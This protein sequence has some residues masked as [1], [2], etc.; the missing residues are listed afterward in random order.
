VITIGGAE[1]DAWLAAL[2]Y[3]F[4]RIMALFSSAPLLS[5][6]SV[7]RPARIG[8][9]LMFTVL[10]APTLPAVGEA[11]PMSM[12]G[13]ILLV[14]QVLIG[15]ALGFS[16]QIAFA[17]VELAGD[18]I[19][20][21]MSLSFASF[22]DPQ[23]STQTPLVGSFLAIV[24]LLVFTAMNGHL[25]LLAALADSFRTLP[26]ATGSVRWQ[27]AEQLFAA[28]S[29]LFAQGLQIALPVIAAML[30]T[31]LA[32]GVLTRTAPQLNLLAVGF[33]VTLMTGLLLLLLGMPH[34]VSALEGVIRG[35]LSLLS[36]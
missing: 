33:P 28:G 5:H 35:G 31:N 12:Q 11:P 25:L 36:R 6:A 27:D 30:V 19:G 16:L 32:L 3:P 23:N 7:P 1:L 20:L 34:I 24:L 9:A 2:C 15:L 8:L 22:I 26:V 18:M 29:A 21:Q 4:F 14:Q 10:I 17:A 13:V